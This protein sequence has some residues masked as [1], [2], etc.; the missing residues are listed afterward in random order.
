[1]QGSVAAAA[2]A[3]RP[4]AQHV[5]GGFGEEADGIERRGE[6]QGA[7]DRDQAEAG[8]EAA[9]AAV[10]CGAQDGAEGLGPDG[11]GRHAGGDGGERGGPDHRT[12]GLR[13][14]RNRHH[15][16]GDGGGR[17]GGTASGS[18]AGQARVAGGCGVERGESGGVG[19]AEQD[20]AGAIEFLD[21][22]GI[23][24]GPAAGVE[25]RAV[26]GGQIAGFE[27]VFGAEREAEQRAAGGPRVRRNGRPGEHLRIHFG[28]AAQAESEEISRAPFARFERGYEFS[29][30]TTLCY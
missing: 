6:G 26:G 13:P 16:G 17:S 11:E 5:V 29:D 19:L 21:E 3:S 22:G 30:Q 28:D 23:A 14:K 2:E 1:M 25:R 8:F 7:I 24:G 12:G 4:E 10:G 18:V 15:A 20:G 27:D 9:D